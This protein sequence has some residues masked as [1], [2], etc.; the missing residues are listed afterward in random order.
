MTTHCRSAVPKCRARCAD[1][2]AMF[3]IVTSRTTISW[4]RAITPRV[5]QRRVSQ[6]LLTE[7]EPAMRFV[8][9]SF[10]PVSR[11]DR[12]RWAPA[13]FS[14]SSAATASRKPIVIVGLS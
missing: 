4:A 2:S 1:G 6:G 8:I 11:T 9:A 12:V 13:P 10:F 5:S 3:I 14:G 7:V